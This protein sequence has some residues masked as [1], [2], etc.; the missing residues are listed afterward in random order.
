MTVNHDVV[1]SSPT[2]GVDKGR[3][4]LVSLFLLELLSLRSASILIVRICHLL[5]Y[6][7]DIL[8]FIREVL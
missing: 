6:N 2:G 3:L 8:Y 4:T 1:G 7:M 5:C